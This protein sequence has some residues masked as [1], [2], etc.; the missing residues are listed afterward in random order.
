M[1]N[2]KK[3]SDFFNLDDKN[4][5]SEDDN[6]ELALNKKQFEG[7]KGNMLLE[8][9]KTFKGDERFKIDKKFENDIETKKVSY[10]LKQL[11]DA[12]D[13]KDGITLNVKKTKTN[14]NNSLSIEQQLK[15]E[16][17]RNIS[18][19]AQV[20]SNED[21]LSKRPKNNNP[22]SLLIK[23]FDPLLNIGKEIIKVRK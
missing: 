12:F 11:T 6:F 16:K 20:I 9:Q 18:I 8:L 1:T 2:N 10:G 5:H 15:D 7:N 17:Q 14:K 13:G 4:E 22:N 3:C 21:F 19:L 23:R